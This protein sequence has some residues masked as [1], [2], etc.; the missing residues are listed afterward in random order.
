MNM[1]RIVL[2]G[3]TVMCLVSLLALAAW[4]NQDQGAEEIKLYGGSRGDVPFPHR[5]HQKALVDCQICHVLYP[6]VAGSI[7]ELKAQGQLKKKQVMNKQCTKCH[8]QKK[9]E[10]IKAGPV[11]CKQCHVR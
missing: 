7:E 6:Q 8:K 1:Q 4:S 11:T 10:G 5:S 2:S 3:L 9:K